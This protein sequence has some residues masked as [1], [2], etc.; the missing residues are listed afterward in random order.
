MDLN[1]LLSAVTAA[2]ALGAFAV[3]LFGL[4]VG[5][6]KSH[7]HAEVSIVPGVE[8]D[9]EGKCRQYREIH[10]V[11]N[12]CVAF[13]VTQIGFYFGRRGGRFLPVDQYLPGIEYTRLVSPGD[14]VTVRINRD[15]CAALAGSEP[16]FVFARIAQGKEFFSHP[17]REDFAALARLVNP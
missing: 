1:T 2:S 6:R 11:N 14:F 15:V 10:V 5:I 13:T 12:G 3:G 4:L 9:I 8:R 7:P 16:V 17:V